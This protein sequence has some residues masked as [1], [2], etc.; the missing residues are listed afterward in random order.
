MG[1]VAGALATHADEVLATLSAW[2]QQT[3]RAIFQRL[4]TP[5]RTRA[6]VEAHELGDISPDVDRI[7]AHLVSARLLVV[8]TR[9]DGAR[10]IELVHES[11]I[12]SWPTLLRWLDENQEHAAYL[13]QVRVTAKQWD[14]KGRPPGLLWRGEAFDEARLFRARYRGELAERERIYL[15]AVIAH[16]TRAIRR[17]RVGVVGAMAFLSLAVIGSVV[18]LLSIRDAEHAAQ[19]AAAQAA[20]QKLHAE[21]E[22]QRAQTEAEHARQAEKAAQDALARFT[23]EQ[24]ATKQAQDA[25]AHAEATAAAAGDTVKR[26]QASSR[27]RSRRPSASAR[28]RSI[29]PR[30]RAPPRSPRRRRRTTRT[31]SIRSRRR[32]ARPRRSSARRSPR[33]PVAAT[34]DVLRG[35]GLSC[36]CWGWRCSP[37]SRRRRARAPTARSA[38]RARRAR[39]RAAA[40]SIPGRIAACDGLAENANCTAA[41]AGVCQQGICTATAWDAVVLVGAG[42]VALDGPSGTAVDRRGDVFVADADHHRVVELDVSGAITTIAGTGTGGFSGDGGEVTAAQLATPQDVAVDGRNVYIVDE[43]NQRIRRIDAAGIITTIA[44]TGPSG[45]FGDNGPAYPGRARQPDLRGGR[46]PRRRVRRRHRQQLD[47]R[48]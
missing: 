32:A 3:V 17:R 28:S 26:T 36:A 13:A 21:S 40:A 4:V 5:E 9:G 24:D 7:V 18:A 1:G 46:R 20:E 42:A 29:R 41:A 37:A 11:L 23:E 43:G 33:A 44:G 8:Q 47:P 45:S 12:H 16:G 22:Q 34:M 31:G 48:D 15:D 6:I 27:P 14:A 30:R 38:R 2:D 39:P 35:D 10:A 19:A 25:K